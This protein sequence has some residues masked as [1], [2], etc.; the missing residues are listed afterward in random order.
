MTKRLVVIDGKSIFYRGYYAMPNLSTKE[1]VPTGGVYGFVALSL[2]I[3]SKLNPDYI[4]VAWDKKGTSIRRRLKIYSEYKAGRKKAPDDFYE[5]IPILHELLE[6]FN[7]PLYELDDY[8]ADDIMGTLARLAK[9][10]GIETCLISSDLDM[11]QLVNDMTTVYAIKSGSK[12][13]A[14]DIPYFEDKYG[15]KTS[16]FLD[17]KSLMG[18]SSDNIPGVPGIGKKTA[19]ALLSAYGTL[20]EVFNNLYQIKPSVRKK[21][22]AGK[23]L[24]YMSKE[25]ADIWTNAPIS[26]DLK[27]LNARNLD[28]VKLLNKLRELEFN[29]LIRRLSSD[30]FSKMQLE[31]DKVI[32]L[33]EVPLDNNFKAGAILADNYVYL[34]NDTLL[35]SYDK[36]NFVRL[37]INDDRELIKILNI[38]GF[39]LKSL[40]K[41][42]LALGYETL[43]NVVFDVAQGE[44]LVNPLRAVRDVKEY[45]LDPTPE[46]ILSEII[47]QHNK[48]EVT[49]KEDL[50][51]YRLA[52]N[53]DFKL[54]KVL[55]KMEFLGIRIDKAY[56]KKMSD[57]LK[58]EIEKLEE[59]AFN[60][61]GEK[62]NLSSPK[63]LS[64]VLFDHMNLPTKGI[65]KGKTGYST[66]QKEL[67][68]L[69][70]IHPIIE[71]I[72]RYR[73]LTKLI[74][75]YIDTLPVLA[76]EN[77]RVHTT[78]NQ[79]V[80]VTGRLSSTDPNLQNIPIRTELGRKV[81]EAFV[82]K[83]GYT[84]IQ[85][86][87]SQFE[88]R[89]A[90][91]LAG[92]Q[93]M[94]DGFN[95]DEDIHKRTAALVY[96]VPDNEVTKEMRRSAKVIN[97]GI[98]YG[99]SPRGLSV[100]TKMS[101]KEAKDFIER[102]FK[103]RIKLK[104]YLDSIIDFAKQ[105]GY[106]KT[107][108]GRKRPA[109][110]INSSNYMVAEAA[111]RSTI[112]MPI[113]GTE[114]DLMKLSM[115]HLDEELE[116][117]GLKA[118]Q[119]IQ[120]HDSI[121]LE[122]PEDEVE[123]VKELVKNVMENVYPKLGIKLTVDVASG[124][125]WGDL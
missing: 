45:L 117:R 58:V 60:L 5:Q 19:V 37:N 120:V 88:L 73:E 66:G 79:N 53:I 109:N 35:V 49:F 74:N 102:Y 38:I 93:E 48:Q 9:E 12:I 107:L 106:V 82:P 44:F 111:K 25:L 57:K 2:E 72:E 1:G 76:D 11:L 91:V 33:K 78:F 59:T 69:R 116:K 51:L 85:A 67:D 94:V 99:M 31:E 90:A 87:Y 105:H 64:E 121:L 84:F 8:E 56:L 62:F 55:A 118:R 101:V 17:L 18:D 86:D 4:A 112:N 34:D 108:F 92:D 115:I 77:D 46:L 125:N 119:I 21:L 29:S 122:C 47:R 16:Q 3:I 32:S 63:Q 98:L 39:D 52:K 70:G 42:L 89:L 96:G 100:A 95:R 30:S 97:F 36:K 114:A 22:E 41:K 26:L 28:K 104:E 123:T 13:E 27:H 20:D 80:V 43:P 40:L 61:S 10:Q 75:T 15:L 71:V 65:K 23:D 83:E 103:L 54:I 81:R 6:A 110:D 68:K 24:A 14:F 50:E 113:Q 124:D 7:W